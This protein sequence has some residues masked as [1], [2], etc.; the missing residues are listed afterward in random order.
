[1]NARDR[2]GGCDGTHLRALE[3]NELVTISRLN[4]IDESGHAARVYA[5]GRKGGRAA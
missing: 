2:S 3:Q 4:A 1:M 5:K